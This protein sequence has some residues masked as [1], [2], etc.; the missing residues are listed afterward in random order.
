DT[1]LQYT[2]IAANALRDVSN[3]AQIPFL[4]SV[5]NLVL[6]LVPLVQKTKAQKD[7]CMRMVEEIHRTL[8]AFMSLSV[9]SDNN[10]PAALLDDIAQ[11]VQT[12]Q[13]FHAFLQ[14]DRQRGRIKRLFKQSEIT[15]KLETCE[16]DLRYASQLFAMKYG[17]G[18]SAAV[19][20]MDGD[21][22]ARHQELLELI[23]TRSA[24]FATDPSIRESAFKASSGSLSLLPGLPKIFYGR[25]YELA[26]ILTH[27]LGS[28]PA[29]ILILGPG[30]MG[31]TTLATAA[32]CDEAVS[33]RYTSRHFISCESAYTT[34]DLLSSIALHLGLE[35]SSR[36]GRHIVDHFV[37]SGPALLVLDNFETPWEPVEY[38]DKAEEF[39]ASL[40]DVSN[41]AL[42]VTMRG[43][44]R[45]K[46][47]WNRPFLPPLEPISSFASRQIFFDIA[48]EPLDEEEQALSE[49][50]DLSGSLPLAVSLMANIVSFEGYAGTLSRW[51]HE[52]T[53]LISDG[54]SKRSNLE[55]SIILSLGSPRL[56]SE[57][58]AKDLLSLLS[59]LPDGITEEELLASKVPVP[60]LASCRLALLRTSLAYMDVSRRLKAL[61][62]IRE[63]M[64]RAH[65]PAPSL[66]TP[67]RIYLEQ[68]LS[69]WDVH[70]HLPSGNLAMRIVGSLGNMHS[71]MLQGLDEDKDPASW[72]VIGKSITILNGFSKIMLKGTSPLLQRVPALIDA[73]GDSLM[74]WRYAGQ[75]LNRT[76]VR[77]TDYDAEALIEQGVRYFQTV[78]CPVGEAIR[79]YDRATSYH[80]SLRN[81]EQAMYF[82]DA[83][84]GLA[85]R[86]KNIHWVAKTLLIRC[87]IAEDFGDSSWVMDLAEQA[88]QLTFGSMYELERLRMEAGAVVRFG[89][90]RQGLGVL[91]NLQHHLIEMGFRNSDKFLAVIDLQADVHLGKSEYLEAYA[92]HKEIA[93]KTSSG[94]SPGFH[95]NSLIYMA[96]IGIFTGRSEEDILA[97]L[98][99]AQALYTSMNSRRILLCTWLRAELALH[100][101]ADLESAYTEY[102]LCIDK[103]RGRFHDIFDWCLSALGDPRHSMGGNT[104]HWATAYL[105][106]SCKNKVLVSTY[107]ALRYLADIFVSW[108]D[109]ETATNVFQAVLQCVTEADNHRLKAECMDGLAGIAMRRGD[110]TEAGVLWEGA[111]SLL[112]RSSQTKAVAV[113]DSRLKELDWC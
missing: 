43:A 42:I 62:P 38:R 35:N 90:L 105:A 113:V 69:V 19:A 15:L 44:E 3:L 54:H 78:Q 75:L 36:L 102:L 82:S 61:S 57:P 104:F 25:D 48:E 81:Y 13:T 110:R 26:Q 34:T 64:R 31:K 93:A 20:E 7:R 39:L 109:D 49:L 37:R 27:L 71:L 18:L 22:E 84:L 108:G 76:T 77:P 56:L 47:K 30:G 74:R 95:A 29:R 98:D 73:T 112:V 11:Y 91:E 79:F 55:K 8:C 10:M 9:N 46:I 2:I 92:L 17:I 21:T 5:C 14:T 94:V 87:R 12:L 80:S 24:S 4:S 70:Q 58:Y 60:R 100:R 32:L 51:Q 28:E 59:L 16:S 97:D 86:T 106:I 101:H 85:R 6:T 99:A 72:L 107:R 111:R 52:H 65:P 83:A 88:G 1:T 40:A 41:L 23:S 66:S 63:Y 89:R 103:S 67:V 33:A 50:L 45:P 96:H 53:E 68:I